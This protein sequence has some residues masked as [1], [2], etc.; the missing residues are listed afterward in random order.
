MNKKKTEF[1]VFLGID[2]IWVLLKLIFLRKKVTEEH[3]VF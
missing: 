1:F 2:F 3:V